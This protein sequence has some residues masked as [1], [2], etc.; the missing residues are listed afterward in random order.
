MSELRSKLDQ[1]DLPPWERLKTIMAVLRSEQGCS[2]DREQTHESL[3]PYLIE[4]SYE[5]VEAIKAGDPQA[6][7]DE[8][9]DLLCQ[10]IFHAQLASEKGTFGADDIVNVISEKLV[11][12]HPHVF[13]EK[14]DLNPS[15][16]RDMWERRKVESGEKKQLLSGLPASMPALTMAFRIGEKAAG[17]GFDWNEAN[18]VIAKL[19]EE[20]E[21]I[22]GAIATGDQK[23]LREEIGDLLFATASLARK[24]KV[25]PEEALKMALEKFR[26]RFARLENEVSQQG[27]KVHHLT[28]DQLEEIWQK[29]KTKN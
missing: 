11:R 5:V 26:S 1:A 16:V 14:Q 8:L 12:R 9:G 25:E 15:E 4:E 2:W 21:E 24:L 20:I 19:E 27:H 10:I 23:Q 17:V 6:L 13:G 7:K 22:K 28:L 3:L 29:I 18:E